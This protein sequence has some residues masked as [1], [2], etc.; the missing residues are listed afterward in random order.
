MASLLSMGANQGDV[1]TISAQGPEAEQAVQVL[2]AMINVGA[3]Q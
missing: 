3:G 1:L 2:A